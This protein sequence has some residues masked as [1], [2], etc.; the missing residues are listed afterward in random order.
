M[1]Q[2]FNYKIKKIKILKTKDINVQDYKLE[3][4]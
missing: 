1:L 2:I 3:I 4:D